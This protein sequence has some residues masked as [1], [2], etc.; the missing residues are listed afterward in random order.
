MIW[1]ESDDLCVSDGGAT[2][3]NPVQPWGAYYD[4]RFIPEQRCS[5]EMR[6]LA[7]QRVM[8]DINIMSERQ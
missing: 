6:D 8:K 7:L 1:R 3:Q 2:A 5:E 4:P